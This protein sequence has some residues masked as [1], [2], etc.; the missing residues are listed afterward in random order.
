M[1]KC[2]VEKIGLGLVNLME[3]CEIHLRRPGRSGSSPGKHGG[4]RGRTCGLGLGKRN[5]GRYAAL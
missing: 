5:N 4:R 3:N 2:E 1:R